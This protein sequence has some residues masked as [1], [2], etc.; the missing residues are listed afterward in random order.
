MTDRIE[1]LGVPGSPYTRKMLALLRYRHIPYSVIWASHRNAPAGYPKP[2]VNLLPTFYFPDGQG[3][4]EAVVDSTPIAERLEREYAGRET[5][6]DDP[7]LAYYN[8]LIED[9]GDEWLTKA[10]FHFRWYHEADRINAGP[11]LAFWGA[12]TRS[13][14]EAQAVSA[15]LTE[16]QFNRLYVVG[17]N[18][19][20]AETIEQSY[21]RLVGILDQLLA[22]RGFVLGARPSTADFAL[23]GQLTQLG[24]VEPTSAAITSRGSPRLRAWIDGMEDLSGL[25]PQPGDWFT[26]QQASEYLKPLLEEIGRVY[27]PFLLANAKAAESGSPQV[28]AEIDGRPWSQPIFP[29]QVKCLG[30]LR[31]KFLSLPDDASATVRSQLDGTGCEPLMPR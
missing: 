4:I 21:V 14:D 13:D 12:T 5:I 30:Q 11:Q 3:G 10:M 9:F 8:S 16:H 1:L 28:E 6:P 26:P 27:V 18:E 29:Y 2:K 15:K 17:S 23:F 7:A 24:V 19:I 25:D 20:T 31:E 22:H